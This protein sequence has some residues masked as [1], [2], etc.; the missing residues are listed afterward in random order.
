[1]KQKFK[2]LLSA[3]LSIVLV[4]GG[5]Q[6]SG[7]TSK[8]TTAS[9]ASPLNANYIYLDPT[10]MTKGN[11]DWT[12]ASTLYMWVENWS[13]FKASNGTTTING[14]TLFYWDATNWDN[15]DKNFALLFENG[16]TNNVN[17]Q[18]YYRTE[19]IG[20]LQDAKGKV[21]KWGGRSTKI[22]S[23]AGHTLDEYILIDD[24]DTYAD[25]D[26][27]PTPGVG[28]KKIYLDTTAYLENGSNGWEDAYIYL[29]NKGEEGNVYGPK[30]MNKVEGST[31]V[32]YFDVDI[33]NYPNVIFKPYAGN[34]WT[35]QTANQTIPTD[36]KNKFT[37]TQFGSITSGTWGGYGASTEGA[38]PSNVTGKATFFD[39]DTD[40]QITGENYNGQFEGKSLTSILR[41]FDKGVNDAIS[42]Y[43]KAN[44]TDGRTQNGTTVYPLYFNVFQPFY[45]VWKKDKGYTPTLEDKWWA[46]SDNIAYEPWQNNDAADERSGYENYAINGDKFAGKLLNFSWWVNRSLD[47]KKADNSIDASQKGAVVQGLVDDQLDANGNITTG[48]VVLPQF[49]PEFYTNYTYEGKPVGTQYQTVDFPFAVR[50]INGV[51]YYQFDSGVN[52]GGVNDGGYRDVVRFNAD[53]SALLYYDG[54]TSE[55]QIVYGITAEGERSPGFFPFNQPRESSACEKS[56]DDKYSYDSV[57]NRLNYGFGMKLEI[58]FTMNDDGT[59]CKADKSGEVPATFEF[60]G[61]DDVWIYV[62]GKLALDLGG[63][64]SVATGK[65]DFSS[66]ATSGNA[67]WGNIT[68]TVSYVKAQNGDTDLDT[69]YNIESGYNDPGY[70]NQLGTNRVGS[71]FKENTTPFDKTKEIHTLT[72]FYEERGMFESNFKATFNLEQP[73]KLKVTNEVNV[74]NINPALQ[75]ATLLAAAG[76]KFEYALKDKNDAEVTKKYTDENGNP[77]DV[78]NGA[79]TL[80]KDQSAT[81]VRQFDRKAELSLVQTVNPKYTTSWAFSEMNE[82][83]ESGKTISASYVEGKKLYAVSDSRAEDPDH[84]NDRFLLENAPLEEGQTIYDESVPARVIAQYVQ[85]PKTGNISIKKKLTDEFESDDFFIFDIQFTRVFGS[86]APDVLAAVNAHVSELEYNVYNAADKLIAKRVATNGIKIQ[87]GQRAEITNVSVGSTYKITERTG[88]NYRLRDLVSDPYNNDTPSVSLSERTVEGT[89]VSDANVNGVATYDLFTFTNGEVT[90]LDE[91][92]VEVDKTNTIKVVPDASVDGTLSND[93]ND[94]ATAYNNATTGGKKVN[95]VFV[96]ENGHLETEHTDAGEQPKKSYKTDG[97]TY[98]VGTDNGRPII[99]FTPTSKDKNTVT[100]K[101]QLVEVDDNGIIKTKTEEEEGEGGPISVI[102][103]NIITPVITATNYLYKA[104]DDIYVLDYG[105]DVNLADTATNDGLF[106]NDALANP[107]LTGTISTYWNTATG[108][109]IEKATAPTTMERNTKPAIG[110]YGTITPAAADST[111]FAISNQSPTAEA[112]NPTVTYSLKKFLANKDCFHYNV[113]VQKGDATEPTQTSNRYRVNLTSNVTIMPASV[114]YYEDNFNAGTIS[115]DSTVKIVYTGTYTTGNAPTLLQSNG[116]SEQY[117][118]DE[119][120]SKY[121]NNN[122]DSAGSITTLT[123]DRYN[124]TASFR[125]TGTGF[126]IIAR[127]TGNSGAIYCIVEK[128]GEKDGEEKLTPTKAIGVD[129]YYANGNLYQIPVIHENN[130]EYDTYNVTLG[131]K[132][133]QNGTKTDVFL[134]GIRIYNPLG[135][136]GDSAY[137]DNEEGTT[138]KRVSDL[139]VGDGVITEKG[140]TNP[141]GDIIKYQ[142]IP[143]ASAALLTYNDEDEDGELSPMGASRVEDVEGSS[144]IGK[145]SILTYLNAGPT[146]E[147]YL[148]DGAAL[149]FVATET[150]REGVSEEKQSDYRTIQIEAKLLSPSKSSPASLS[151]RYLDGEKNKIEIETVSSSTAMYYE[152]PVEKCISLGTTATGEKE[153]LVVILGNTGSGKTALSFSNVKSNGYTLSNPLNNSNAEKV[154]DYISKEVAGDNLFVSITPT[155]YVESKVWHFDKWTVTVAKDELDHDNPEFRMYYVKAN[156]RKTAIKVIAEYVGTTDSGDVYSLSFKAP[157]A[158]GQFPVQLHAIDDGEESEEYIQTIMKVW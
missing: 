24:T 77:G 98:T 142:D 116:Q 144:G 73:T 146:N 137:I 29:F 114:V 104:N 152:V 37:C 8:A 100:V 134:D 47:T 115:T 140:I 107:S 123:A 61:D 101:Y 42:Q 68:S 65:I 60:S 78:T 30:Q 97:V 49:N 156:G 84:A 153:Y 105:L 99:T 19:V 44:T 94:I 11:P 55:D 130:L 27:D 126:D 147:T 54:K 92:L 120:Y 48:G 106:Q 119:A 109:S 132:A 3:I 50:N 5:L 82:K 131:I 111:E 38:F 10:G 26:P 154:K 103:P 71:V 158:T 128:V 53:K 46:S 157:N 67:T 87:A 52:D 45:N 143:G 118:H 40:N 64:H 102:T 41:A 12:R 121:Y 139:I 149:A 69:I 108:T 6:V 127:T 83:E 88:E 59:V 58:Q 39:L 32:F 16:W 129:T 2:R 28:T 9:A 125:F 136:S 20:K 17:T 151:L 138:I 86:D 66:L 43:W 89:V 1:M 18:H 72:I 57:D 14:K 145:S 36:E 15:M 85:N 75:A 7:W 33:T 51:N 34:D 110:E 4:I 155:D 56:Q 135:T 95:I 76:D 96:N 117:G 148:D 63:D 150:K 62:D 22:T 133:N 74:D 79:L 23:G 31:G 113:L 80:K 141:Q 81:F 90:K 124:T 13:G 21:F 25:S 112:V 35:R 91:F 70:I 122:G 93:L